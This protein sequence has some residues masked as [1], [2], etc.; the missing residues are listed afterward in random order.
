MV[1]RGLFAFGIGLASLWLGGCIRPQYSPGPIG[2]VC[3]GH[4]GYMERTYRWWGDYFHEWELTILI[5]RYLYCRSIHADVPRT[6]NFPYYELVQVVQWPDDDEFI[7]TLAQTINSPYTSYYEIATNTLHFVQYLMPYTHDIGDY[8]QTPMETLVQQHG[9]CEDGSILLVSLLSA[10]QFPV[11]LGVYLEP[12][13]GGHVFGLV[14][15]SKEWVDAHTGP[16]NKCWWLGCWTILR[17]ISD[18]TLW[19]MA[20]T[21]LDP[22]FEPIF[23][24]RYWGLGCGTIPEAAWE[25]GLVRMLDIQTGTELTSEFQRYGESCASK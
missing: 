22:S 16:F 6:S 12:G 2:D 10:L 11:C 18:N 25:A 13:A 19:A 20:E 4:T 9:D 1:K 15:V 14:Q 8:W 5:P 21:T 24:P 23:D 3:A 17:R 7:R